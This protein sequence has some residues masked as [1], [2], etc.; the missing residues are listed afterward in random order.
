MLTTQRL[1][2]VAWLVAASPLVA[3]A[4]INARPASAAIWGGGWVLLAVATV[5]LCR[6]PGSGVIMSA[7][8]ALAVA[9]AVVPWAPYNAWAFA[10]H[11]PRYVDSPATILVVGITSLV[12]GIPA[13]AV[14]FLSA[15]NRL[16]FSRSYGA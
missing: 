7:A 3:A 13:V 10:T 6:R 2:Q 11:D 1:V 16:R 12:T 14:L 15:A 5:V 9:F 4:V 8:V